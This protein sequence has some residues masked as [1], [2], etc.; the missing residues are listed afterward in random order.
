MSEFSNEPMMPVGEPVPFYRTWVNALTKPNEQTYAEMA[1][2]PEASASKAYLW[3]FLTGMLVYVVAMVVQL[4]V[5]GAM[6]GQNIGIFEMGSSAI[7]LICAAPV[8]AGFSVLGFMI[9]T[10]LIQWVARMFGGTGDFNRLAYVFGAIAA[11]LAIL[12]AVITLFAAIP[13]IGVLFGLLGF[14]VG[15]YALILNIM[16]VKGVNQFG[17]GQ[18]AGS[19]LLPGLVI[20]FLCACLTVGVLMALGPMIGDVFESINQS[21]GGF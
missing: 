13:F 11:P 19:V 10:A 2:S 15:I 12:S 18:A 5:G 1:A 17:W 4:I 6:G 20:G 9:S 3:V 7:A 8:G 16:A 21:L 14:A